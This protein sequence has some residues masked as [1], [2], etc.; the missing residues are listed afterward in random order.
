M[1]MTRLTHRVTRLLLGAL[2]LAATQA[3]VAVPTEWNSSPD[4]NGLYG[5]CLSGGI[6]SGLGMKANHVFGVG[7]TLTEVLAITV[8]NCQPFT[9][10]GPALKVPCPAGSPYAY[11]VNNDNDGAG[12]DITLGILKRN[13]TT[14]PTTNYS[15]CPAGSRLA[16]KF[17]ILKLAGRDPRLV[18]GL[19]TLSCAAATQPRQTKPTVVP[20]PAGPHPYGYCLSTPNDGY[21]N[22]ITLGVVTVDDAGDP[23]G[24]YGECITTLSQYNIKSGFTPKISLV[25]AVGRT[26][27]NVRTIDML[28]CLPP[29][30]FGQTF[31]SRLQIGGVCATHPAASRYD[32]MICGK[33][34]KGNGVVAGVNRR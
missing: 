17:R 9:G 3:S 19:V 1:A 11:C 18:K 20:C 24:L 29:A 34:A 32:Y 5:F 23:Y 31:P 14:G 10:G 12:N 33:D 15:G 25:T 27:D 21:G 8:L 28:A 30:G 16:S 7:E 2:L 26:L 22:A 4:V 13:Q 6:G